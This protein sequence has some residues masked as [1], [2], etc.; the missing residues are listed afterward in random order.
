[1]R[2]TVRLA[3]VSGG[4]SAGR[5]QGGRAPC[6]GAQ[7]TTRRPRGDTAGGRGR[8]A[9]RCGGAQGRGGRECSPSHERLTARRPRA[10]TALRIC[11]RT[12]RAVSRLS[13]SL[14]D[15]VGSKECS[16][17][18]CDAAKV[19]QGAQ[20]ERSHGVSVCAVVSRLCAGRDGETISSRPRS[21]VSHAPP[22]CRRTMAERRVRARWALQQ[23]VVA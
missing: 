5:G 6:G 18:R 23:D 9:G 16:T 15:S 8:H 14:A 12:W 19:G 20:H 4:A 17:H 7:H 22:S 21:L 13:V 11:K 10:A 3:Q 2:L 1:M